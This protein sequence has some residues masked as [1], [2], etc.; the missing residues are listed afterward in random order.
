MN[1]RINIMSLTRDVIIILVISGVGSIFGNWLSSICQH[2][3]LSRIIAESLDAA[4]TLIGF[5][6]AACVGRRSKNERMRSLVNA[7]IVLWL[8]GLIFFLFFPIGQVLFWL[9]LQAMIIGLSIVV[10]SKLSLRLAAPL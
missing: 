1:N 9:M 6:V 2:A 3:H 5:T 7:G 8:F 10:G 4:F